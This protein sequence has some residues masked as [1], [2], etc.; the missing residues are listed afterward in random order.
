MDGFVKNRII[1]VLNVFPDDKENTC[2]I[3]HVF[4]FTFVLFGDFKSSVA[5]G[6]FF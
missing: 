2:F 1:I 5:D 3:F 6:A 4:F